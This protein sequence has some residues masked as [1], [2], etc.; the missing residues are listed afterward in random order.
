MAL[1]PEDR[2]RLI[3]EVQVIIN[4]A[5]STDFNERIC[6][7][8]NVNYIGCMRMLELSLQCKHL[9]IFTHVSTAYV[10]C[11]KRGFIKEQIYDI[12]EDSEEIMN[13]ILKMSAIE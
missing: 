4:C 9:E 2:E 8:I 12:N 13:R 11:D 5:A 3:N 10:N 6:D 7:A 1:K